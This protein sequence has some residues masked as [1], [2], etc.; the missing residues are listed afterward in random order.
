MAQRL[1]RDFIKKI[2][3]LKKER[4]MRGNMEFKKPYANDNDDLF[5]DILST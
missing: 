3:V 2:K 1:N 5:Y 4:K